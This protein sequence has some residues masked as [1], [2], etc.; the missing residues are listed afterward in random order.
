MKLSNAVRSSIILIVLV[1]AI[2]IGLAA[3]GANL[4]PLEL[5]LLLA[6]LV[7]G[8]IL[9]GVGSRSDSKT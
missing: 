9:I 4:G 1:V 3:L 7:V 6:I 2:F 8:L 5:M